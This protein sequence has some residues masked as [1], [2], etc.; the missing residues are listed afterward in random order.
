[1]LNYIYFFYIEIIFY[2]NIFIIKII[3]LKYYLQF[4]LYKLIFLKFIII[5][6]YYNLNYLL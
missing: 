4:I 2:K 6:Q 5:I 3:L 1:L